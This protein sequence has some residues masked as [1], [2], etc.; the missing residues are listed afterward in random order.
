MLIIDTAFVS[1]N[2]KRIR[3]LSHENLYKI[4][5]GQIRT[6]YNHVGIIYVNM[7]LQLSYQGIVK[8]FCE[9]MKLGN[10]INI[11]YLYYQPSRIILYHI[12]L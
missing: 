12:F 7:I 10:K 3:Y 1:T 8:P 5:S 2:E 6:I 11:I 9:I 4:V